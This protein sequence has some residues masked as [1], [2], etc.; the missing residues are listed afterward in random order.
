M[1]TGP[2][3]AGRPPAAAVNQWHGD[4]AATGAEC[5]TLISLTGLSG[6]WPCVGNLKKGRSGRGGLLGLL[7]DRSKPNPVADHWQ[8]HS[9]ARSRDRDLR[10]PAGRPRADSR[11]VGSGSRT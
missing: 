5:Q 8:G 10:A 6:H 1:A 11:R 2:P 3:A 7:S 4:A 9:V